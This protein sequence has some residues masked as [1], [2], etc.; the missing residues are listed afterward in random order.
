MASNV[1]VGF[2]GT[3]RSLDNQ[4]RG[5][6][7]PERLSFAARSRR[8]IERLGPYQS[9]ALLAVPAAFPGSSWVPGGNVQGMDVTAGNE[10]LATFTMH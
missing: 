6:I 8:R 2:Q 10:Q 3:E 9:L 1:R 4:A 5:G 7:E